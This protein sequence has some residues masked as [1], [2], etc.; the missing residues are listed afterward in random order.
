ML[1]HADAVADADAQSTAGAPLPDHHADDRRRQAR[2]LQQ[3]GGDELR[4]AAFL[5]ADAGVGAGRV[6]QADDRQAELGRQ[7][8]LVQRLAIALR[9]SAAVEALGAL[10]QRVPLL[11]ADQHDAEIAQP[12]EAGADGAVVADGAVAVQFDEL[13]EDQLE[14]V[15]GLRPVAVAGDL[16]RLPRRQVAV[17]LALEVDRSRAACCRTSS[18]AA[19]LAS[20]SSLA[21]SSSSS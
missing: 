5:G 6:D 13:V 16:D 2:H 14:I 19:P 12:G 17:D 4:L 8:H 15:A 9:M 3:A 1:Q 21:S 7:A 18:L 20:A 10:L 11:M